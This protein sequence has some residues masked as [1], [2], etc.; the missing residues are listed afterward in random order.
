MTTLL[1]RI[2]TLHRTNG[3]FTETKWTRYLDVEPLT[4]DNDVPRTPQ[5]T[6]VEWFTTKAEQRA[7][8]QAKRK[9]RREDN[10]KRRMEMLDWLSHEATMVEEQRL[11]NSPTYTSEPAA[12]QRRRLDK[13]Y[14]NQW[15]CRRATIAIIQ[16][17]QYMNTDPLDLVTTHSLIASER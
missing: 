4:E 7:I 5:A 12:D 2:E 17:L 14:T 10:R 13:D 1:H 11:I 9:E 15:R 8:K 16:N 6:G 3:P